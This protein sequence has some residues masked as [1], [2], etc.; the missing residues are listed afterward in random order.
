ME[1][2]VAYSAVIEYVT[3]KT[4]VCVCVFCVGLVYI[5]VNAYVTGN[6]CVV[7]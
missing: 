4:C 6:K 2:R 3:L 5:A 7:V 1:I